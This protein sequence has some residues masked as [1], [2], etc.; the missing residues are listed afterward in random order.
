LVRHHPTDRKPAD[1]YDPELEAGDIGDPER[2]TVETVIWIRRIPLPI[3]RRS[4][5]ET[6]LLASLSP[7]C[8]RPALHETGGKACDR[9]MMVLPSDRCSDHATSPRFLVS[10]RP[11]LPTPGYETGPQGVMSGIAAS[12]RR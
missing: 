9:A 6:A 1:D 10:S 11:A 7:A 8:G 2:T 3:P 4:A 12:D 5:I